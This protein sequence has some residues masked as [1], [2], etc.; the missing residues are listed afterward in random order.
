MGGDN[1]DQE[2]EHRFLNNVVDDFFIRPSFLRRD[3]MNSDVYEQD[4]TI[5]LE[6]DLPG[7]TQDN[8]LIEYKN[9]YIEISQ[10][11]P[12]EEKEGREYYARERFYGEYK[13]AYFVG[14]VDE[15]KIEATF[16]NGLLTVVI[17]KEEDA[18]QT[19]KVI[20]IK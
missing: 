5:F 17:P 14:P 6:V 2:P 12:L 10:K 19:G 9:G 15:T 3:M 11:R 20:D 8:V 18:S 1:L 4:N 16:E 13:R 7:Y